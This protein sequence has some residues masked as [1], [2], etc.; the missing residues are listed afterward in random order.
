MRQWLTCWDCGRR[1][2]ET[3]PWFRVRGFDDRMRCDLCHDLYLQLLVIDA[4]TGK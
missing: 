1:W 3:M 2:L 4:C